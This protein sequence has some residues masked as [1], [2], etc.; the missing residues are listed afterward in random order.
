MPTPTYPGPG[1]P[2]PGTG[3]QPVIDRFAYEMPILTTPGSGRSLLGAGTQPVTIRFTFEMPTP[4][5][6]GPGR[7]LPGTGTQPVTERFTYE[8]PTLPTAGHGRLPPRTQTQPVLDRFMD[9]PRTCQPRCIELYDRR[10]PEA[11]LMDTV[12]QLQLEVDTLK[13]VQSRTS[14]SDAKAPSVQFKPAEFI[15]TKVSKF[16]GVTGWE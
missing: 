9:D 4:T 2:L 8:L 10:P 16:S 15:S 7:P 13:L 6:S 12:I 3:T 1:R 14:T 11:Y 5:Y